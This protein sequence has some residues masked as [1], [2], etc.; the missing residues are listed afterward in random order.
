MEEHN[1]IIVT[2]K[3]TEALPDLS[4]LDPAKWD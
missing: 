2:F 4:K 1:T 3:G